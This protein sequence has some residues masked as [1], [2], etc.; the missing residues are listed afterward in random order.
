MMKF[1]ESRVSNVQNSICAYC[2]MGDTY[3]IKIKIMYNI[4]AICLQMTKLPL[5]LK[6][7]STL[8]ALKFT[9]YTVYP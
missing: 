3:G 1:Y 4:F 6:F 2:N 5:V 8:I 7:F 9:Y